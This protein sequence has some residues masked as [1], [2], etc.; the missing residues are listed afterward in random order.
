MGKCAGTKWIKNWLNFW[1]WSEITVRAIHGIVFQVYKGLQPLDEP[2][3]RGQGTWIYP[4]N[5]NYVLNLW[6]FKKCSHIFSDTNIVRRDNHLKLES[7]EKWRE[8]KSEAIREVLALFCIFLVLFAFRFLQKA[9]EPFDWFAGNTP[10]S[11]EINNDQ[12][13]SSHISCLFS[14]LCTF[15]NCKHRGK[16]RRKIHLFFSS[17]IW[18]TF[19]NIFN[20]IPLIKITCDHLSFC[21]DSLLFSPVTAGESYSVFPHFLSPFNRTFY[22]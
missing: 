21:L 6:T 17:K 20:L 9:R 7:T 1:I 3:R 18:L 14:S 8:E 13:V 15:S 10:H 4:Q 2:E 5:L 12:L 11:L 16:K 19:S 22:W